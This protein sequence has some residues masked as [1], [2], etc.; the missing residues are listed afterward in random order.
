MGKIKLSTTA[1]A[2]CKREQEHEGQG[3]AMN[4][5]RKAPEHVSME[6]L[7]S[8]RF[9]KG[10]ALEARPSLVCLLRRGRFGGPKLLDSGWFRK[11]R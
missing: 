5:G 1:G 10:A 9:S 3:K 4:D 6:R 8:S 2:T 11:Q 7:V